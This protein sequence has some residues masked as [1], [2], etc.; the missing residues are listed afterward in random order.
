M[1]KIFMTMLLIFSIFFIAISG[2]EK[3]YQKVVEL[4]GEEFARKSKKILKFGGI[5]LFLFSLF[6]LGVDFFVN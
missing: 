5:F 6:A 4:H 1:S 3:K 2:S